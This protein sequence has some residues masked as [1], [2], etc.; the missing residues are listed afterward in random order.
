M[1][2][3]LDIQNK[4]FKKALFGYDIVSIE[5]Y[6]DEVLEEYERIYKE[7]TELKDRVEI[8]SDQI[9]QYNSM[10]ETLKSTLIVAQTT[11]EQVALAA[12]QKG[13]NIIKDAQLKAGEI[14]NDAHKDVENIKVEYENLSKDIFI[15]KSRYKSFM[16]SQLLSLEDFYSNIDRE[17]GK[18]DFDNLEEVSSEENK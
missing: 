17:Q 4:E 6:L 13:D 18:K 2:T 15:F 8:L 3:P 7:N 16:E 9:R 12:R 1:I 14:I 5:T 10:E 11:A